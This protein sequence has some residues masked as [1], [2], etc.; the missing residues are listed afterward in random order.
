[1]RRHG[2]EGRWRGRGPGLPQVASLCH[3]LMVPTILNSILQQPL[4]SIY[5]PSWTLSCNN[6]KNKRKNLCTQGVDP[7]PA[8]KRKLFLADLAGLSP[9]LVPLGRGSQGQRRKLGS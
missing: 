1:M 9:N 7:S 4:K 8:E 3:Y 2:A 6:N 5:G